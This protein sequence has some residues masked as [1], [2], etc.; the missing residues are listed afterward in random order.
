MSDTVL[1]S[2]DRNLDAC[3]GVKQHSEGY[4]SKFGTVQ[5]DLLPGA[6]YSKTRLV[7]VNKDVHTCNYRWSCSRIINRGT[8]IFSLPKPEAVSFKLRKGSFGGY[9]YSAFPKLNC[10]CWK[11]IKLAA[12]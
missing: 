5:Y 7:G 9:L 1:H 4:R 11:V 10:K 12:G 3:M 8:I 2:L 6:P